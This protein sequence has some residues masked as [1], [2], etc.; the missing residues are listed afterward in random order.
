MNHVEVMDEKTKTIKKIPIEGSETPEIHALGV[1]ET[2]IPKAE[3][4]KHIA[5]LGLGNGA[6]L[7]KD[8]YLRQMVRS[9][10]DNSNKNIIKAF[11]TIEA[12]QILDR[13]LTHSLARSHTHLLNPSDDGADIK[14]IF[15]DMAINMECNTAPAGYRLG[16]LQEKYHG[17]HLLTHLLTHQ[18]THRYYHGELG[19][20]PWHHR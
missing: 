8:I 11:I 3:N 19:P 4:C 20:N 13:L 18:L 14:A 2:I 5:L 16:Y 1:W 10:E 9:K 12:S 15:K 6:S 17:T 7:C